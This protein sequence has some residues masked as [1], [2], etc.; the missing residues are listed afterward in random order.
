MCRLVVLL[1]LPLPRP[2]HPLSR[3]PARGQR[4][5]L[6]STRFP[7]FHLSPPLSYCGAQHQNEHLHASTR[8]RPC[9][10][11][12][13]A[14]PFALPF[15]T[16]AAVST[17]SP[18]LP[19]NTST[20]TAEIDLPRPSAALAGFR[21]HEVQFVFHYHAPCPMSTRSSVLLISRHS[22]PL[23]GARRRLLHLA[24][25]SLTCRPPAARHKPIFPFPCD[26]LLNLAVSHARC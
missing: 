20:S 14:L 23:P 22:N 13:F 26:R 4:F 18:R 5:W 12:P 10:P 11:L 19:P 3:G 7:L 17:A 21:L 8:P 1:P 6:P 16:T 9:C 24:A 15:S 2:C 25:S